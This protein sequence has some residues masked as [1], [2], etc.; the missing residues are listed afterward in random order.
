[1]EHD[2]SYLCPDCGGTGTTTKADRDGWVYEAKCDE[3]NG[4]GKKWV[5]L[6]SSQDD[7]HQEAMK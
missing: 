3:C 5:Q 7:F 2:E 6:W 4:T 1:M